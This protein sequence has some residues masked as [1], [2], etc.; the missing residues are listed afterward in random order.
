MSII[1]HIPK[2]KKSGSDSIY[3]KNKESDS[4]SI[5]HEI[6]NEVLSINLPKHK[7]AK[8]NNLSNLEVSSKYELS[9]DDKNSNLSFDSN[10]FVN[11]NRN[12]NNNSNTPRKELEK[13]IE[14]EHI[15]VNY[16]TT[17]EKKSYE[18]DNR[19]NSSIN[20]ERVICDE[21]NKAEQMENNKKFIFL[22]ITVTYLIYLK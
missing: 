11:N 22:F 20:L 3:N 9:C 8:S 7:Q 14:I 12:N 16:I 1:I 5:D 13:E 21:L 19:R 2:S 4:S 15:N 17:P 10:Y 18:S 6:Q